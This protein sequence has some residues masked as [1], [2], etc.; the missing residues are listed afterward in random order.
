MGLVDPVPDMHIRKATKTVYSSNVRF[1]P[2][3]IFC[4]KS[5]SVIAG[6]RCRWGEG[7]GGGGR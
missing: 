6:C 2:D 3:G 1:W 4:A 7:C 5:M